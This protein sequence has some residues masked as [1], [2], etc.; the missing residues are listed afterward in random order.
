MLRLLLF[1]AVAL[2]LFGFP[3]QLFAQVGTGSLVSQASANRYALRRAW[4][5]RVRVDP[6]HGRIAY[7]RQQVSSSRA[8]T[9]YEVTYDG[10]RMSFSERDLDRFGTPLGREE[11]K[12]LAEQNVR[13]LKLAKLNPQMSA[14]TLPEINLVVVTNR[15]V[16]QAIDGETGR[17][18]WTTPVGNPFYHSE[19]PATNDDYVAIINGSSIYLLDQATG[20]LVWR[21]QARGAPSAGPAL[22]DYALFAPMTSGVL[23]S[24]QLADHT[25]RP[26]SIRAIGGTHVQPI[27]TGNRI[28][29]PTE[30]GSL[31]VAESDSDAVLFRLETNSQITAPA[32]ALPQGRIAVPSTDGDLYCVHSLTGRLQ[33]RFSAGEPI[34]SAPIVIDDAIYLV[35]DDYNLFRLSADQGKLQWHVGG[36]RGLVAASS[37]RLYCRGTTGRLVILDTASGSRQGSLSIETLDFDMVNHQTDRI[38]VGSLRGVIQCLHELQHKWPLVHAGVLED[39]QAE[40]PPSEEGAPAPA[41]APR[42]TEPASPFGGGGTDPFTGGGDSTPTEEPEDPFG[43]GGTDPFGGSGSGDSDPFGGDTNGA[44]EDPFGSF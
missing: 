15:G 17:T 1:L 31:Y 4:F 7:V 2:P 12:R 34:G 39:K 6:A 30:R 23:E 36:V 32:A 9:V 24:Y 38:F 8:Y 40:Q 43:G 41:P 14:Q 16:V 22:S 18:R 19:A 33:W 20:K 25:K 27:F 11:A 44:N 10:G 37:N 28:A 35:S 29:W 13:D 3:V 5:T 26:Y 21:R 42:A